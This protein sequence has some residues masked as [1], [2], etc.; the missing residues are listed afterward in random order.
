[1][2]TIKKP[3]DIAQGVQS[4]ED[5]GGNRPANSRGVYVL[6]VANEEGDKEKKFLEALSEA[7]ADAFVRQGWTLATDAETK[8][9]D[10]EVKAAKKKL[11]ESLEE[12]NK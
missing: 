11:D 10:T 2:A 7:A 8:Q 3:E 1:M 4:V 5:Q 12:S 9:Y 6:E